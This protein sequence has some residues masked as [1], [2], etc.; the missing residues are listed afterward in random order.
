MFQESTL[1]FFGFTC[2]DKKKNELRIQI[3]YL[4]TIKFYI[5]SKNVITWL[6]SKNVNQ[7]IHSNRYYKG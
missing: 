4:V 6:R 7:M 3:R 1:Q 5:K 2:L